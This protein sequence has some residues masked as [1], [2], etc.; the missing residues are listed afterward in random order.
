MRAKTIYSKWNSFFFKEAPVEGLAI[1]R[2]L[3]G[4]LA[5]TTFLQDSLILNDLWGQM[6]LQ[7]TETM[8]KNY[9]FPILSIFQYLR[10]T[11]NLLF[12]LVILQLLALFSFT[13]GFKTKVANWVAFI[14]M[15][16]FHQRNINILSSADLLMRIMFMLMLFS[17]SG[18]AYSLDSII[19]RLKGAPLKRNHPRWAMRLIQIQIA[20]VYVSTVL[21]KAKGI[22]WLDGSAV[23]YAT[24]LS[25][26]TRFTVPVILDS[27]FMI[28]LITW[29]TLVI[30]LALGTIIFID[31]F[32]K[33][34][35]IFGIIFHLGIEYMMSIPQFEWL[36]I[37]CLLAMFKIEDYRVFDDSLCKWLK[38][39]IPKNKNTKLNR[40]LGLAE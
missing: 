38:L 6:G 32:R 12:A 35:I 26:L 27:V 4:L 5:L 2:I 13:I 10:L 22:T 20:V 25:D 11:D 9:S 19:A 31:E 37:V 34:L 7:S 23:Y 24:R 28:K 21:A 40:F 33:E 3:L 15:V 16:S 14:L 36:M 17:P 8:M 30:E 29:S 39:K 18:N 1:F